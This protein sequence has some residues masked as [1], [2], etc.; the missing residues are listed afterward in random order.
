[1]KGINQLP[2]LVIYKQRYPY[3]DSAFEYSIH[4]LKEKSLDDCIDELHHR[5][6]G[7]AL[8]GLSYKAKLIKYFNDF[9]RA[10]AQ[11]YAEEI[12]DHFILRLE[13]HTGVG[14]KNIDIAHSLREANSK[15]KNHAFAYL[16]EWEESV[17]NELQRA[18]EL[19]GTEPGYDYDDYIVRLEGLV[20]DFEVLDLTKK[21]CKKK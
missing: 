2:K 21:F 12:G 14:P 20:A 16:E 15:L 6:F 18:R 3:E 9:S 4:S 17:K 8:K 13:D 10:E 19:N 1:M 5:Y 7:R 11:F